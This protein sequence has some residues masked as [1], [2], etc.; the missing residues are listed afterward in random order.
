MV[1][2]K[3]ELF[4]RLAI[5]Q[6]I[7]TKQEAMQAIHSYR[8]SGKVGQGFS[9]YLIQNEMLDA[10][11]VGTIE[12]AISKRAAGHVVDSRRRVPHV[13]GSHRQTRHTS[14]VPSIPSSVAAGPGRIILVGVSALAVVIC[15]VIIVVKMNEATQAPA[16]FLRKEEAR[17]TTAPAKK[18]A[19]HA[20]T[21]ATEEPV[22]FVPSFTED[23][24]KRYRIAAEKAVTGAYMTQSD[25]RLQSGILKLE[26]V[27]EE[28]RSN[29]VPAGI[30]KIVDDA[31]QEL[32]GTRQQLY[33]DYLVELKEAQ[34]NGK[35]E[36]VQDLLEKIG[37]SCGSQL[38]K[39]AEQ[40]IE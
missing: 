33:D 23:E 11:T 6:G 18:E 20:M 13:K 5:R 34:K 24:L 35:D 1:D 30:L 28:L 15:V 25:G 21:K 9:A 37:R 17:T 4:C 16:D 7:L 26:K 40:A 22:P 36:E 12:N 38:Q 31:T 27:S 8:D 19:T 2:S 39:Q 3:E 32:K 14:H 10:Q 29:R